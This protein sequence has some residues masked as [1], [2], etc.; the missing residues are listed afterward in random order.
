MPKAAKKKAA[1]KKTAK[2]K[3]GL[4]NL[5]NATPPVLTDWLGSVREQM[6]ELKQ[7]EGY[8]KEA[9]M[10]R[11]DDDEYEVV[12]EQFTATIEDVEQMRINTE[13]V[14]EEM[15]T[16]WWKDHCKLIEYKMVKT[17]RVTP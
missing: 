1:K 5:D 2:R 14:K 15:G 8:Y 13:A 10:A 16:E 6:K 17:K 9:L 11:V 12:G 4:P 7:L 3:S